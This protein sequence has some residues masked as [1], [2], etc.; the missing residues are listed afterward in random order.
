L[1]RVTDATISACLL[2]KH[3]LQILPQYPFVGIAVVS[4]AHVPDVDV[5]I[6]G[7]GIDFMTL[8]GVDSWLR[9]AIKSALKAYVKPKLMAIDVGAMVEPGYNIKRKKTKQAPP[10]KE[11]MYSALFYAYSPY[12][13]P[14]SGYK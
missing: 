4:F 6:S 13:L 8:G 5:H 11:G 2:Y 12:F 1:S 14:L 3:T 7:V 9:I 10:V